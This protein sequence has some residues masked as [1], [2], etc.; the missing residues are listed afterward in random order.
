MATSQESLLVRRHKNPVG[1]FGRILIYPL[2][3][4]GIWRHAPLLTAL[5]VVLEIMNWTVMPPVDRTLPFIQR[6]IDTELAWL[7]AT[8][9]AQKLL[10]WILLAVFPILLISG[11]WVHSVQLCIGSIATIGGFNVLM[12]R[13]AKR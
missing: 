6:V 1:I 2:I 11:L 10:S 12:N 4:I 5:G 7:R 3:A 8:R 9:D 13:I